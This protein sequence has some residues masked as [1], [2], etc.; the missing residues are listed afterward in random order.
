MD[1]VGCVEEGRQVPSYV[2]TDPWSWSRWWASRFCLSHHS[3]LGLVTSL[4]S[5]GQ[6]DRQGPFQ[7]DTPFPPPDPLRRVDDRPDCRL[8]NSK[9]RGGGGL[10]FL[11]QVGS[12]HMLWYQRHQIFFVVCERKV[13]KH[14]SKILAFIHK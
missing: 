2:H 8:G 4:G 7:P 14:F 1:R 10:S 6:N 9:G 12:S 13:I 5:V 3:R 11:L